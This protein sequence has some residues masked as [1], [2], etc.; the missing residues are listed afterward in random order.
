MLVKRLIDKLRGSDFAME[1]RHDFVWLD[2][3]A[4]SERSASATVGKVI[5]IGA[6][7]GDP[8]LLTVKALRYLQA[9]DII[10][11]DRLVSRE[12]LDIANPQAVRFYVG[13]RRDKHCVPQAE[14]NQLLA[15]QAGQGKTVIRLKGGDPFIFGR[16]GEEAQ[17]LVE[18]NIPFEIVPGITSAA[19]CGAYAGIPL[20]HRDYAQACRFVTGHTKDGCLTLD[21]PTLATDKETLVFYMGLKNLSEISQKLVQHGLP[22][23]YPVAV[24]EQG[25]TQRQRVLTATLATVVKAV[26]QQQFRSPSLIIV[27]Q[28]V[29]LRADLAWF[30]TQQAGQKVTA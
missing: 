28:V 24:I 19:G 29:K 1:G 18:Q 6:G 3:K 12:I 4:P 16:G 21:W 17:T 30:E 22:V 14:I 10:F 23:D 25:T 7:P 20:T 5:L 11:Y 15:E 27:G 2:D 9:A 13:K 8:E 26:S